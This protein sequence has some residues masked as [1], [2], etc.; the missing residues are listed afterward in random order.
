M[1]PVHAAS[2]QFAGYSH[3]EAVERCQAGVVEG[4]GPVSTGHIQL[5][6]QHHGRLTDIL[7]DTLRERWPETQFRLHANVRVGLTHHRW[8][9]SSQHPEAWPYFERLAQLS[10]RLHA[11][12]YT[13]HAGSRVTASLDSLPGFIARLSD[14]FGIPVGIEGLYPN[15]GNTHLIATWA[16]YQWLLESGMPYAIDLSHLN[17]VATRLRCIETMLVQE[18]LSSPCCIEVHLS[19]NDGRRDRHERLCN[20]RPWWWPLFI[21]YTHADATVFSEGVVE[22]RRPAPHH[23]A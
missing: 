12:A 7:A 18:L 16:E 4:Y 11:P 8:D 5:C 20:D 1:R 13:L 10:Q 19:G 21:Q 17:I 22:V 14:L 15:P 23:T 2:A 3:L 9:A 6:P